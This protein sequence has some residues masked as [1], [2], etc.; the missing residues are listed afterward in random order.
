MVSVV[1]RNKRRLDA[2]VQ[3]LR[4][5]KALRPPPGVVLPDALLDHRLRE[6][7]RTSSPPGTGLLDDLL[8]EQLRTG[9][10]SKEQILELIRNGY[11]VPPLG[12]QQVLQQQVLGSP[13][14]PEGYQ[15]PPPPPIGAKGKGGG[16]G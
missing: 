13:G 15:V 16:K 8:R 12:Q 4:A 2:H 1:K 7:L 10:I 14:R 9:R 11:Q 6:Q 5:E 3:L